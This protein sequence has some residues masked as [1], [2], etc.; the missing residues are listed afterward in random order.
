MLFR[1]KSLEHVYAVTAQDIVKAA[2]FV[3]GSVLPLLQKAAAN[4]STL[5]AVTALVSPQAANVERV[6][7]SVLG[8]IIKTLEDAAPAAAASGMNVTLDA[9]LVADIKAIIPAVKGQATVAA[10]T[11]STV[12]AQTVAN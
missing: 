7:F 3:E 8:T 9:T 10:Q 2:K 4:A 6:A 5:E 11:V 12:A 1:S